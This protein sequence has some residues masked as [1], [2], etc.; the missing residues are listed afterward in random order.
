MARAAAD[1]PIERMY[2][3]VVSDNRRWEGFV[4]R[5]GDVFVCTPP[6][7]GT[8]WM[9]AIVA[10][11]MSPSAEVMGTLMKDAPWIDAR[12]EA[13]DDVLDRLDAQA[14]RRQ[15]KTHTPADGIPWYPDASYIV[16]SR[17]GRDAFMSFFNH[18]RNSQQDLMMQLVVSAAEDGIELGDAPP[19]LDDI[20][21]FFAW[22]LDDEPMWFDHV[23]SFWAHKEE[24]NVAFVH[25]DDLSA[26]LEGQMRKVADF[27][28]EQV[29][30]D[31]WPS[32]VQQ[33]TF[34]SMRQASLSITELDRHFVGGGSTFFHKG[35][36]GRWRGVLTTDELA[37]FDDRCRKRLQPGAIEWTN[38]WGD[39]TRAVAE[40]PG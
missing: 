31:L 15:I 40:H 35:T 10:S 16:V 26:D 36:N 17:D 38:R 21:S 6:K 20:H 29:P 14:H 2:R 12:Y 8:T 27:L 1:K 9:Q 25:Y 32:I 3:T 34:E 24:P 11:I 7:C 39:S 37:A 19:P 13:V 33:C 28:G 5:P 4:H 23:A 22:W 18:M 30:E